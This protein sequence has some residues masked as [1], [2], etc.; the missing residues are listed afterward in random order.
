MSSLPSP[1]NITQTVWYPVS[2]TENSMSNYYVGNG[3]STVFNGTI[4]NYSNAEQTVLVDVEIYNSSSKERVARQTWDDVSFQPFATKSFSMI[5]PS[6]LPAGNYFV[7]VG[8]YTSG[9]SRLLGWFSG[10]QNFTVAQ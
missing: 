8:V 1:A 10:Y 4:A 5:P 3:S 6:G 2:L 9:G 7:A